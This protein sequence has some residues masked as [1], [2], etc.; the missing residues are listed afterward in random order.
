MQVFLKPHKDYPN[1][2][3]LVDMKG[4]PIEPLMECDGFCNINIFDEPNKTEKEIN[5][6]TEL[7]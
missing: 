4:R 2:K 7:F 1:N 6:Q 5:F 3:S